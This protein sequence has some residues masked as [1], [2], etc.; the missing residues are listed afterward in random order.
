MA[1]IHEKSKRMLELSDYA[2]NINDNKDRR[3]IDLVNGMAAASQLLYRVRNFET[4]LI[5]CINPDPDA[6]SVD[7]CTHHTSR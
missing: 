2:S 5:K 4:N 3:S 7:H 1:L 6:G